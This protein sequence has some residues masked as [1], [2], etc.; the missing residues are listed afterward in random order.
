MERNSISSLRRLMSSLLV[1]LF[2][3]AQCCLA[4]APTR[5]LRGARWPA[6]RL[7]SRQDPPVID[8]VES[9]KKHIKAPANNKGAFWSGIPFELSQTAAARAGLQTLEQSV[10]TEITGHPEAQRGTPT[11]PQFWDWFSE[12]FSQTIVESGSTEV[13]V[14]LRAPNRLLAGPSDPYT[15]GRMVQRSS[16]RPT[17]AVS[18]LG[19][20][21]APNTLVLRADRIIDWSEI[22]FPIMRQNNI[23]VMAMHP[24][25]NGRPSTDP[26]EI[27]PNDE[28]YLWQQ[29]W[30]GGVEHT[31]ELMCGPGENSVFVQCETPQ[32]PN[33]FEI[34]C[35]NVPGTI[36][37]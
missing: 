7:L 11:N 4:D 37:P 31:E 30:Q 8:S 19:P 13:T 21:S 17:S 35:P 27:W 12:G 26:Y 24:G 36:E 33:T 2:L 5:H 22:E 10:G 3:A 25:E 20:T 29:R 23:R 15:D 14:L 6:R 1:L 16:K 32:D 28:G 18:R 9:T 34:G